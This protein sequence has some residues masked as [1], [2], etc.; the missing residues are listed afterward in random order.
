MIAHIGN[1]AKNVLNMVMDKWQQRDT[2]YNYQIIFEDDMVQPKQAALNTNKFININKTNIVISMFGV[3]DRPVDDIANKNKVISLSCSYGKNQLPEYGFNTSPQNEEIYSSFL[4]QLKKRNVKTVALLGNNA[5]VS[6]VLLGYAAQSLP[7]DGI[8]V[9]YNERFNYGE[10]DFRLTIQ[11]MEQEKPDY[12]VLFGVEPFNSI[13]LRQYY[14]LT[15]K[16]NITSLGTFPGMN[17][18]AFPPI[19]DIWSIYLNSNND[20]FEKKYF[21]KYHNRLESCSA[22]LYD[23][24][25]MFIKAFENTKPREGEKIPNNAD[26]LQTVK[27][28][29]T[30]YGALGETKIEPN[31][32]MRMNVPVR[33]FKDGQWLKVEE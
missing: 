4:H 27:E 13:F 2:K 7:K 1:S 26:V 3:V 10:T 21:E 15:G 11:K 31:G 14:E 9:L 17:P 20:E 8:E 6:N 19:N 23:G 28:F 32:I 12:Y 5:A 29:K 24:L 22:N 30:W 25:D 18:K 33:I 16:K